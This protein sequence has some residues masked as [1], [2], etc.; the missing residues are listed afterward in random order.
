IGCGWGGLALYL[1]ETVGAHVTGITLSQE[2]FQRARNRAGERN[3]T[4]DTHF[5]LIDYRDVE[6]QFDRI[7]SVG[8]F[9]HVGV[10]FYE[11]YFAKCASLLADDGVM[12]LHSI[13]RSSRPGI[14]N[15]W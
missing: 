2:Q 5:R 11:T 14:T 7:V 3:L 13:G 10:S 12:L 8:M 1:A 15:P 6:G 4:E 9:E